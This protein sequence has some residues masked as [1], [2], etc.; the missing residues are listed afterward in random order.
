MFS[1]LTNVLLIGFSFPTL[2]YF[3]DS[4]YNVLW[5]VFILEHLVILT[6]VVLAKAIPDETKKLKKKKASLDLITKS[7]M[8]NDRELSKLLIEKIKSNEIPL[9]NDINPDSNQ[10]NIIP[11]PFTSK[12]RQRALSI[13]SKI[14]KTMH[15]VINIKHDVDYEDENK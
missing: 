12:T 11:T 5:I 15:S 8:E 9:T 6:K 14:S 10:N 2:L 1:V 4:P 3:T 13:S 7:I